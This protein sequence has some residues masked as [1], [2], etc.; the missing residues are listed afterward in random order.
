VGTLN[1]RMFDRDR[2]VLVHV[3]RRAAE[4]PFVECAAERSFI[5]QSCPGG[6]HKHTRRLQQT[7]LR[8]IDEMTALWRL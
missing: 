7:Q 3:E 5:D 8:F 6:V 4:T 1:Q 2:F